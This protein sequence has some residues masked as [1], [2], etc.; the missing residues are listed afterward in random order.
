MSLALHGKLWISYLAVCD[1]GSWTAS[2]EAVTADDWTAG[3][4]PD[5]VEG[6]PRGSECHCWQKQKQI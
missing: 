5:W 2:A 3:A 6:T 4:A 1:D